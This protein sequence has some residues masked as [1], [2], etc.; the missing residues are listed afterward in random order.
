LTGVSALQMD[1]QL[2]G[3]VRAPKLEAEKQKLDAQLKARAAAW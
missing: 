1:A 3:P 2:T